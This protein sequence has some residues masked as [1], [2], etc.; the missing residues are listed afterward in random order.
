[1]KQMQDSQL[2]GFEGRLLSELV[3]VVEEEA[4]NQRPQPAV[5]TDP[6]RPRVRRP[7]LVGAVAMVAALLAVIGFTVVP[8][9][10]TG[11]AYAVERLADGTVLV[12][13]DEDFDDP[14][15][16]ADELRAAGLTVA[17]VPVPPSTP[18]LSGHVD[19]SSLPDDEPGLNVR[20]RGQRGATEF[21]VDPAVFAGTIELHVGV[22]SHTTADAFAPGQA[23]AGVHCELGEP[24]SPADLEQ[25]GRHAGLSV[26]WRIVSD[27]SGQGALSA[28]PS[29]TRPEGRV[30]RAHVLRA[31]QLN[32]PPVLEVLVLPP[33]L[34]PP[35][36]WPP[37]GY[38]DH[39][40]E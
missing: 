16:L 30:Y 6:G 22:A 18:D 10:P 5:S 24:L 2:P 37:T 28:M 32:E 29:A 38:A 39:R 25:R 31:E 21:A 35:A 19:F 26:V 3:A 34:N 13:V 36:G 8:P 1:M 7:V 20:A 14:V 11:V 9:N 4:R 15:R 27:F 12:T 17:L 23:L 40:C 33:H